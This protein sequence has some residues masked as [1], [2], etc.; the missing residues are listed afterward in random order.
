MPKYPI[1]LKI[2]KMNK[3]LPSSVI[4]V[5]EITVNEGKLQRLLEMLECLKTGRV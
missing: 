4:K 2:S 3:G 1:S 5:E